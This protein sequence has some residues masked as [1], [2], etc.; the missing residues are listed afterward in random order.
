MS[1][2]ITITEGNTYSLTE[3][4]PGSLNGKED[5]IVSMTATG[6]AVL[7]DGTLAPLGVYVSRLQAQDPAVLVRLLGKN[8]TVRVVQAAAI[9]PGTR[10]A[11]NAS[12][13]VIAA[14]AGTLSIGIKLRPDNTGA[15]GDI[16]EIADVLVPL[17]A[18][19]P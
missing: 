6:T 3:A 11:P 1:Q 17:A 5:H 2:K 4:T 14:T 12:G 18:P 8:G 9:S 15:A 13:Q 10:V 7:Y 16:I 19:T